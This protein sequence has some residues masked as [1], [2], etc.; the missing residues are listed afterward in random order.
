MSRFSHLLKKYTS[1][2]VLAKKAM[3]LFSARK[4]VDINANG[5]QGYVVKHGANAG[6][7]LAHR[8]V[9]STNNW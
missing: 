6:R 9:K 8:A 1:D 2:S 5:T 4:E 3:M 7:A